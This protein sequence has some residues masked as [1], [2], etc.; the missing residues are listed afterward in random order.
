MI[1]KALAFVFPGQ[2]SQYVGMS[3]T[4]TSAASEAVWHT[5]RNIMGRSFLELLRTG[6]SEELNKTQNAQPALLAVSIAHLTQWRAE[7]Q[8]EP[9]MLAGHSAGQYAA[10]VASG[11][12][13]LADAL[14][15]V[16]TRARLMSESANGAMAAI[17]GLPDRRQASFLNRAA[18]IGLV[19]LA[20]DNAPG[21]FVISG[22]PAAVRAAMTLATQCG[23]RKVVLLPIG[24]ASHSPLMKSVRDQMALPLKR[25]NWHA[26]EIP[27]MSNVQPRLLTAVDEFK[28]E[29]SDHLTA[30]VRWR[31]AVQA[32]IGEGINHFAEVGPGRVLSGLI[33]RID[34]A[35]ATQPLDV[36]S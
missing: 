4:A 29:L 5:V 25:V 26:I 18:E 8:P 15:L 35:V 6:P 22:Q 19:G 23:A 11:A 9:R 21:Q 16:Q 33:K 32:M 28:A 27:I 10:A 36:S 20:G 17:V 1:N 14:I 34:G 2:G 7:R 30:P 13:S 12:L 3:V 24:V 31:E